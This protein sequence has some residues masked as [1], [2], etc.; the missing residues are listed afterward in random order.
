MLSLTAN[1]M[2]WVTESAS[3]PPAEKENVSVRAPGV[4]TLTLPGLALT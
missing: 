1:V 4:A 2:R 3:A